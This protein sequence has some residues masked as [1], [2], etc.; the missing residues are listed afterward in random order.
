MYPVEQTGATLASLRVQ[1]QSL[2]SQKAALEPK[3]KPYDD[4]LKELDVKIEAAYKP[5]FEAYNSELRW[6]EFKVFLL[7]ML[8]VL[9]FFWLVFAWY[10]RLHRKNSPYTLIL[11]AMV[12]VAA[13][14]FLRVML[15]WFWGLFL[16]RV[17]QIIAEWLVRYQILSSL[18]F[19]GGM[20]FSF[21]VF[22]GAVYYLQKKI[23]DPRR[24]A[25]RRFRVHQCPKCQA[26]LELS[27]AFCPNCGYHVKE[28]CSVCGQDRFID[29]PMC[30][31]CGSSKT[32][33]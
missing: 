13:V 21:V 10:V 18:L 1:E 30:P 2:L 29:L 33:A 27:G 19:Y 9:P 25:I 7:Q 11:T 14:L 17:L 4:Q 8:F 24:V 26:S 28:K 12:L 23:F 5:V 22:G 31:H 6:Y 20:I 16:E 3:T 32:Q 15:F